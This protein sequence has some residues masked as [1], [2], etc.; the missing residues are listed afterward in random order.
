ML[1]MRRVLSDRG[2]DAMFRMIER[3]MAKSKA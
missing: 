2:F 3:Q 1:F